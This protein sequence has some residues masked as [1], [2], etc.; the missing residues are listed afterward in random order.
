[1]N[2]ALVPLE[3]IQENITKVIPALMQKYH[4]PGLALALFKDERILNLAFGLKNTQTNE[5]VDTS[6]VFEGASLTKPLI[7]YAALKMCQQGLLSL[8]T[9]LR[10]YLVK[11][12]R[13][14]HPYLDT[15]TLRHVLLHTSGLPENHFAPDQT[16][17]FD[18]APVSKYGYS[19][20]GFNYLAFVM[21]KLINVPIATYLKKEILQPLQMHNSSFIWEE[22]FNNL[23]ATGHNRKS[24]PVEKWKPHKVIGSCSLQTTPNDFAKFMIAIMQPNAV[25]MLDEQIHAEKNI[26][27]SLGW[28]IE[29]TPDGDI[30]YHAGNTVTFKSIAL[31][32]RN[33]SFGVVLMT[34]SINGYNVIEN[35]LSACVGGNHRDIVDFEECDLEDEKIDAVG[36]ANLVKWWQLYGF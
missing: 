20:A 24:E 6:T 19:N 23:A 9:P 8:D 36:E 34:N 25:N 32:Y 14:D 16:L 7:G 26:Y 17:T 12:Y 15:V 18:F 31:A 30:F 5:R 29:K 27:S 3:K 35:I 21:E 22:T 13:N 1:M 11:P 2:Y 33:Q 28:G 4:I 10:T